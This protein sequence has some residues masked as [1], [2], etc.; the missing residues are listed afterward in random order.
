MPTRT[1]NPSPA[2]PGILKHVVTNPCFTHLS[3]HEIMERLHASNL[4]CLHNQEQSAGASF[5]GFLWGLLIMLTLASFIPISV[6][7][8]F[9]LFA[10]RE[11]AKLMFV[12]SAIPTSLY[13]AWRVFAWQA[14]DEFI[15]WKVERCIDLASR[16]LIL[17]ASGFSAKKGENY[18]LRE[19]VPLDALVLQFG[20]LRMHEYKQLALILRLGSKYRRHKKYR[21]NLNHYVYCASSHQRHHEKSVVS[22]DVMRVARA[23]SSRLNIPIL[24][25]R[26]TDGTGRKA[27]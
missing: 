5:F 1:K 22:D 19:S 16:E 4:I 25:G 24:S 13:T 18:L 7:W 23:M 15:S 12:L 14:R 26:Y 3:E 6:L 8:F 27:D 17:T 11:V 9:D 20:L 10:G 2:V 21:F